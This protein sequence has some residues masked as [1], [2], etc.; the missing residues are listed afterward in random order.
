M[1]G[2]NSVGIFVIALDLLMWTLPIVLLA[3]AIR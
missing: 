1:L 3:F 2:V